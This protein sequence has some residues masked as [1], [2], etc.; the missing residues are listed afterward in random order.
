M[1]VIY[2]FIVTYKISVSCCFLVVLNVFSHHKVLY[3][4]IVRAFLVLAFVIVKY[5]AVIKLE[6]PLM[7]VTLQIPTELIQTYKDANASAKVTKFLA[8]AQPLISLVITITKI[9]FEY[10]PYRC[11]LIGIWRFQQSCD[12]CYQPFV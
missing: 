4:P 8:C 1:Y 12:K 7:Y 3:N 2:V 5:F 11:N 10:H 9:C 6:V